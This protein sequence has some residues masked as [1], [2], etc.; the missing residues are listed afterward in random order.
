[1]AM[2]DEESLEEE[3]TF[4]EEIAHSAPPVRMEERHAHVI[5][6]RFCRDDGQEWHGLTKDVSLSGAF[7][8]TDV[9]PAGIRPGEG[10]VVVVTVVGKD[11]RVADWSVPCVVVR[12]IAEGLG[13]DFEP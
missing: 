12:V 10:G 8:Y 9:P 5:E 6:L 3:A 13:L 2:D 7:L 4:D 1:M 11:G